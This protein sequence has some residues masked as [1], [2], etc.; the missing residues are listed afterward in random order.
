MASMNS[1]LSLEG[2]ESYLRQATPEGHSVLEHVSEVLSTLLAQR[3]PDPYESFELV[4]EYVKKQRD[5]KQQNLDKPQP[6]DDEPDQSKIQAKWLKFSRKLLK[7]AAPQEEDGDKTYAFAPDFTF[8][9]RMLS[10]A[11]Y[12]F[13]EREAFR[14]SC[15]LKRLASEVPGLVSIRFWGKILGIDNDYWIAEGQLEGEEGVRSAGEGD[16]EEADP[17]GLGAN[18]YTYWVLRD[19][20]TGEWEMLP[21]VLPAHIRVARR[22]KKL[23][24]GDPDKD[25]ITFPW[26]PGKERHL[27]RATIAQISSETIVCPAGLWK[28]KEDDPGQI[29]EDPEFEYPSARELLPIESWTH[30]R[31]YINDAG[32]TGYP[33]VDEEADEELYAKIQ[34][35]MEQDPILET[36]RSIAEDPEL[37]TGQPPWTTK[38][39]GDCATYGADA[40][41]YAVTVLKSLRW[42]GAVTVYQNKKFTS[43]Y[44]GYGIRAGLNPFFPVAP[45][46]VQEDPN[47]VDEQPEPQPEDDELS[48]GASQENEEEKGEAEAEEDS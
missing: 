7:L 26:F 33:E 13:S 28:P 11:G 24:T 37:P 39:A 19:E 6:I 3:P 40:V 25:I 1:L 36:T 46:D 16:E 22:I 8:E 34:A 44:I 17:R 43:V 20:A 31:E 15:G 10:W 32:L 45:D 42:P 47:D 35:K 48:D 30:S 18:K 2:A 29:E 21:D 23:F 27:L 9:N 38:L 12:G 41:T 4:S 5:I 14:I